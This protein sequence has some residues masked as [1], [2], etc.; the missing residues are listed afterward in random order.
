MIF[1]ASCLFVILFIPTIFIDQIYDAIGQDP[2]VAKYGAE[3]V[4]TVMPFIYL[5]YVGQAFGSY[6]MNQRV[7]SYS[8]NAIISGTIAH[9]AMIGLFYFYLDW[10]FTGVCWATG[11]MFVVRFALNVGQVVWGSEIKNHPHHDVHF[12]SWETVSNI[13]PLLGICT[14]TFLMSVWG[15]WAFDIFTLMASYLGADNT[16]A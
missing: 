16:A 11:L 10:G 13:L 14:K 7:T 5:Y 9:A 6:S 8:R 12:F 2:E 1:L 4:H 3:F 15:W